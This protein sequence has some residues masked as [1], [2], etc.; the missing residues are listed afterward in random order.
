ML[1]F[2]RLCNFL[3]L[4]FISNNYCSS[5]EQSQITA[6]KTEIILIPFL[7]NHKSPYNK[8]YLNL[9]WGLFFLNST[10]IGVIKRVRQKALTVIGTLQQKDSNQLQTICRNCRAVT[11]SFTAAV[12]VRLPLIAKPFSPLVPTKLGQLQIIF[13]MTL[14][15]L[16]A[17][18]RSEPQYGMGSDFSKSH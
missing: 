5:G 7:P 1:C 11:D 16:H 12:Q 10:S 9:L 3:K 14:A 6:I 15:D 4:A 8:H 13:R 17:N 18:P 2:L